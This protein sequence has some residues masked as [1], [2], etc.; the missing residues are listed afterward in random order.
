M[1]LKVVSSGSQ[2]NA[3]IL[4]NE[5]EALLIE[6]GV[7]ITEIKKAID[8]N[9]SKVV[10][11][12]ITHEHLDHSKSILEVMNS[13]IDVYATAGTLKERGVI[14]PRAK[15]IKSLEEF[16]VGGFRILPF[17]VKHDCAEPV[18]FLINHH[19]CGKTLFLTDSIY[20]PY[21]FNG[22]NNIIIEA[23]YC[24]EI[25]DARYGDEAK[26]HFLRN[27]VLKSHFSIAN[28][29]QMLSANDLSAVNNIVLIHL[30][31]RNSDAVRF[32]REVQEL[33]GKNVTV[34]ENGLQIEFNKTP[35]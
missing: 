22:L 35:F 10:G 1:I 20:S 14:G 23:N 12:I 25:V 28:C 4:E 26:N 17:D 18:G 6:C 34:A 16:Q 9:V 30:S 2:G 33:T 21:R 15:S 29:K 7:S 24:K 13:G 3:Y 8:F 27:R 31:D 19:E 32:Q 5:S 11:C